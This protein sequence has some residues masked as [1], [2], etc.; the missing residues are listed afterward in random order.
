MLT[1]HYH[2]HNSAAAASF[3]RRI[4]ALAQVR[5]RLFCTCLQLL[6]EPHRVALF[7]VIATC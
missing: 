4:T 5:Q 3:M 1:P 2:R 6:L 7:I